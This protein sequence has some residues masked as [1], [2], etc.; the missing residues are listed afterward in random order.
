MGRRKREA[1]PAP[2]IWEIPDDGWAIVEAILRVHYARKEMDRR[3]VD[4]RRVLNGVIFRMRTG[5]QWNNLPKAFGDDSSV[6]RHF[7][8]WCALGVFERIWAALLTECEELGGVDWKWQSADGAM[9]KARFGG[10][11]SGRTRPIEARTA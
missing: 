6:H 7:Q 3:R 1:T 5:C 8:R 2:T 4:L 11:S 10:I 9:G